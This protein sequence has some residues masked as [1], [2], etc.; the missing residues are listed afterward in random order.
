MTRTQ[1]GCEETTNATAE[2]K[3]ASGGKNN[4]I[5]AGAHNDLEDLLGGSLRTMHFSRSVPLP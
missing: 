3:S 1:Q 5:N 2:L 4:G